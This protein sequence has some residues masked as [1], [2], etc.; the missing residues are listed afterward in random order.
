[1]KPQSSKYVENERREYSLYVMTNRA[2]PSITDGLKAAG[3]RVLWT[4]KDG[5]KYK[6]AT[7]AGATMPIH[8]HSS[9]EGA[10]DTLAAPY[11]NN[12]PLFKGDGAFGTLLNPTSYGASRYTSVSVSEFTKD[13]MFRDIEIVPMMENYDGTL[14]EPV[15]FLPLVP[16]VLL[17]PSEGIAVG[18]ATNILPRSLEDIIVAQLTFLKKGKK[19]ISTPVPT[20]TPTDARAV[21]YEETEKGTAY[22]FHGKYDQLDATTI[23]ITQLPYGQSHEKVIDKIEELKEKDI[24]VDYEDNSKD[25]ISI[26]IKFKKGVLRDMTEED[27]LKSLGLI[28]KQFENLNVLDFSH[29]R[30]V[31]LT[32][33]DLIA[34]FTEWRLTWYH[35]R[36]QRLKDLLQE[37][38]QK[39]LDIRT[40][41]KHQVNN[42]ARK[43]QSRAEL[44]DFLKEIK[45]INID[46][47]ADLPIYRFTEE[48]RIKNEQRI[49]EA[50]EKMEY[51]DMLLSN[52]EERKKIYILELEEVLKKYTKGNYNT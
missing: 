17:N 51:Y 47:I 43:T 11:G 3:R 48:E 12:I 5:K 33:S 29:K 15:H 32:A 19:Y 7:L 24:V 49:K 8:P 38:L 52:E 42:I 46:Y 21:L 39:Y 14:M 1:M 28:S 50:T 40:A 22:Y 26:T 9:P 37:E 30:I 27:V 36:Y 35:N 31:N 2:I 25:T 6:S 23:K 41:I 20:F 10:I 16:V 34:N 45:I 13:V 44:K 4:A 18:F